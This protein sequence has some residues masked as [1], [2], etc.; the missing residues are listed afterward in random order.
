MDIP[1]VIICYNN[2]R[3]VQNTL[4]QIL[5]I[6]K[7]YYKNIIIINNNST[8]LNT[9][10]YLN[11]VDVRVI[12]N[13][14][15]LGPWI[16]NT[17]NKHIYDILPEKFILT[18]PDLK[19]NKNIPTNFIEIL[20]N[21]SDKYETSKIGFALD[22]SDHE[23]FFLTTNYTHN[24]ISIYEWEKSFYELKIAD[25]K[26]EL[27]DADIDTTFCL[28]NKKYIYI[29]KYNILEDYNIKIRVGG[30]FTAKHI[31]WYIDNE[32]YN[33]YD[34][35]INNI[36]TTSISSISKIIKSY[37]ENKYLLIYK[38]SELFL[39]E[40]N[41]N[42]SNL[43]FWKDMY[44]EWEN[45][46]FKVFDKYLSKDKVF[47]D[48]GGWIATTSMYG[49]RKSKHVYTIEADNLAFNDMATNLKANCENN[50]TLINKAIYNIDNEKINFGKNFN[51]ATSRINDS[52]SQT[53]PKGVNSNEY[54]VVETITLDTIIKNYDIDVA[55]ISLIKVDIEG[56]EENIL[57]ELFDMRI[58]HE[59]PLYISFHYC[60]W[61]DKNLDRFP[62]LSEQNKKDIIANPFVSILF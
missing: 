48:I 24:E 6:N 19:F 4:S 54:Y 44:G 39:I 33:V 31:P 62:F 23:K 55:N 50:Y 61:N 8:C 2:Y 28:I 14:E 13:K 51:Y 58:K 25:D 21:L 60:W 42:N 56:G 11:N 15:N 20:A 37:I 59:V 9:I 18:D 30:N 40:N 1:I 17:N 32:L 29:N 43:S 35:Y 38:N 34:N 27:Y 47:I 7:E 49:S 12:N 46:T 26:Y 36:N 16:T 10:K 41:F 45:D 5:N 52:M 3:Y 57:D 22:I 53:C